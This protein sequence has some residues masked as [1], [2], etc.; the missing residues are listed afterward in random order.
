[1][2][3]IFS[4]LHLWLSIPFGLIISAICISGAA[5]VFEQEIME[6]IKPHRYFVEPTT[7][8]KLPLDVIMRNVN[9][10]IPDTVSVQ[11][12][13]IPSNPK[14]SYQVNLNKPRRA[15]VYVNPYTAEVIDKNDRAK[16]FTTMFR[17]HRWLL[18]SANPNGGIFWG[19]MI[20]GTSTLLFIIISITGLIIWF[21]KKIKSLPNKRKVLGNRLKIKFNKGFR[22]FNYD[23]HL[24][25]GMYSLVFVLLMAF[26]GLTWSFQWYRKAFYGVFGA[27]TTMGAPAPAQASNTKTA[28][29]IVSSQGK[30]LGDDQAKKTNLESSVGE[31]GRNN[32]NNMVKSNPYTVWEKAYMEVALL[33]P[34]NKQITL[35]N[36]GASV[37]FNNFGNTRASDN[38]KFN[39]NSGE[40]GEVSLYKDS[41]KSSKMR[42]WIYS[43]HVGSWG[44][45]LTR[46][47]QF[48][49]ALLGGLLPLTGYYMWIK[50]TICK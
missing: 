9:S 48:L 28:P 25:I 17:L 45:L 24:S 7:T 35:S 31:R 10:F 49:A 4:K 32:P 19:K 46:I 47:L 23:F 43:L 3:K 16:F 33:N 37:S 13:V 2:R 11:G 41:P 12:V 6:V 38:Y 27:E 39:P 30:N 50:R 44:G 8:G 15:A 14:R 26:T 42:G 29:T 20:V 40:S 36:S 18:D 5:L 22:R 1:M 21:P 34:N